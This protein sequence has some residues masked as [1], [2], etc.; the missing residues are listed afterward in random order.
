MEKA[1]GKQAKG[2]SRFVALLVPIAKS[3]PVS[4]SNQDFNVL[5]EFQATPMVPPVKLYFNSSVIAKN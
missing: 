5:H 2:K 3:Y 4:Q 1:H